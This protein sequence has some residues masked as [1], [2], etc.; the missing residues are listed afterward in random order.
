MGKEKPEADARGLL[1]SPRTWQL[2]ESSKGAEAFPSLNEYANLPMTWTLSA[3][4]CHWEYLVCTHAR[5][6]SETADTHLAEPNTCRQY[7]SYQGSVRRT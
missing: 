5:P 6:W 7:L 1:A 4:R 2:R 3:P